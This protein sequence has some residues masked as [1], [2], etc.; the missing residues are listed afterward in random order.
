MYDTFSQI[1]L[2]FTGSM[3][4]KYAPFPSLKCDMGCIHDLMTWFVIDESTLHLTDMRNDRGHLSATKRRT[5][6]VGWLEPCWFFPGDLGFFPVDG[7]STTY[8][9]QVCLLWLW[10]TQR[11]G[12]FNDFFLEL[13]TSKFGDIRCDEHIFCK[14]VLTKPHLQK[15]NMESCKVLQVSGQLLLVAWWLRLVK[16]TILGIPMESPMKMTT[17]TW[18][19]VPTHQGSPTIDWKRLPWGYT[20]RPV[21]SWRNSGKKESSLHTY[22]GPQY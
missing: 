22:S 11:A 16:F 12:G 1:R 2:I 14:S 4:G 20:L 5:T 7:T 18:K 17:K 9:F 19:T 6:V 21:K 13:F 15:K 3:S 8:D 10:Y